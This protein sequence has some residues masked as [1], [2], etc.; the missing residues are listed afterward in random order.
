MSTWFLCYEL[1]MI[2]HHHIYATTTIKKSFKMLSF[3]GDFKHVIKN[4]QKF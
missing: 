1:I 3:N 4:V 2:N